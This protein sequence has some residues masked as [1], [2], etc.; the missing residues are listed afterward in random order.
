[1]TPRLV[2]TATAARIAH[3]SEGLIRKWASR[4]KL[5]HFRIHN[6]HN[7]ENWYVEIDVLR[8]ERDRREAGH[9]AA[10]R[11]PDPAH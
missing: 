3:C 4:G 8:C 1:M 6:G 7:Y 10:R 9:G 5:R 11:M 2:N